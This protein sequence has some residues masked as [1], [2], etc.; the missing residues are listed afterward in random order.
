MGKITIYIKLVDGKLEYR[1]TEKHEGKTIETEA[2]PGDKIIWTL[3]KDPGI[4]DLTGINIVGTP[5][6]FSKGPAKKSNMEWAAKIAKKASG[7]VS[8]SIFYAGNAVEASTKL[9]TATM[10]ENTEDEDPPII[11]IKG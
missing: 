5:D 10:V 7:E 4:K 8:Y 6:F 9:K 11:K 2:N 3:D 1:D